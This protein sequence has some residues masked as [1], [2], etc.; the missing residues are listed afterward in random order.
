[1]YSSKKNT[2]LFSY[3]E[4]FFTSLITGSVA[5]WLVYLL[6]G[7]VTLY[8]C[9]DFNIQAHFNLTGVHFVT[10]NTSPLWTRDSIITIYLSKVIFSFFNGLFFML[11]FVVLQRKS[12]SLSLFLLWM[13]V[14]SF[15]NSFGVF[16]EEGVTKSGIYKVSQILSLGTTVLII[17]GTAS[18]YLLYLSGVIV[19]KLIL[20]NT[21][22]REKRHGRL[23]R[24]QYLFSLI[25]PW[26]GTILLFVLL[27][28]SAQFSQTTIFLMGIIV[29][30][31]VLWVTP[32][33]KGNLRLKP[34]H[35]FNLLDGL[36]LLLL[37]V[38]IYLIYLLLKQGI[39]LPL[40]F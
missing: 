9:Y 38:L 37:L 15:A 3:V 29:L 4:T 28:G 27:T 26:I 5:L 1:M 25:F 19:G 8:F 24:W 6:S 20:L 23:V 17:A 13:I 11:L 30:L 22:K 2:N 34:P 32:S 39:V 21:K 7:L 33:H 18:L 14:F 10:P 36:T 40:V 35:P 12:S 31:P 16:T